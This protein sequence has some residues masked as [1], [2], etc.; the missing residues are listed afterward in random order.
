MA[1]TEKQKMYVEA[2]TCV[3][4]AGSFLNCAFDSSNCPP[5]ANFQSSKENKKCA[6]PAIKINLPVGRCKSD[7]DG[8]QCT[9]ARSGCF[10]NNRFQDID[11]D[12]NVLYDY[13]EEMKTHF[14]VCYNPKVNNVFDLKQ[15]SEDE[16]C[17]WSEEDCP[18]G[19][20]YTTINAVYGLEWMMK[21]LCKDVNVGACQ[22]NSGDL[23]CA[24]SEDACSQGDQWISAH[25]TLKLN[26]IQ[27]RLCEPELEAS[28]SRAPTVT[29]ITRT[30]APIGEAK[31][32]KT[33][34]NIGINDSGGGG[35]NAASISGIVIASLAAAAV[36]VWI[37]VR[38]QKRNQRETE[39]SDPSENKPAEENQL[40]AEWT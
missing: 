9:S 31:P 14:G 21:C 30:R 16:F 4:Q 40:E 8:R 37:T 7:L 26:T 27:C 35:L 1:E 15:N 17:V 12:C 34:L 2:G 38:S 22:S 10:F 36:L 28:P 19:H 20:D 13:Q 18:Q 3:N 32:K 33:P 39:I 29:S 6:D 11:N 25:E 23:Y 5:G 24:V